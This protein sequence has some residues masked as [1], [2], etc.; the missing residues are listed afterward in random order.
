MPPGPESHP[1]PQV[2][3]I[4]N[5]ISRLRVTFH[6]VTLSRDQSLTSSTLEPTKS[7]F[8]RPRAHTL[9]KNPKFTSIELPPLY[10]YKSS[11]VQMPGKDLLSY[12]RSSYRKRREG[13]HN[14]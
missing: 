11:K 10:H 1:W 13:F 9:A 5:K 3:R 2:V 14:L 4:T 12:K 7:C 8:S 6:N